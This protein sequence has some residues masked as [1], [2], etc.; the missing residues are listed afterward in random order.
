MTKPQPNRLSFSVTLNQ[1]TL[2][3]VNENWNEHWQTTTGSIVK[4]GN[5]VAADQDGGQLA[6]RLPTG[7]NKVELYYRPR[8]FVIG[9]LVSVVALGIAL[10]MLLGRRWWSRNPRSAS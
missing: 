5:K 7:A 6:V 4:L 2:L 10:A 1:P 9:L 8:S 3:I